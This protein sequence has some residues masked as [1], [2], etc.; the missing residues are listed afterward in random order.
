MATSTTAGL[1]SPELY[2]KLNTLS[3]NYVEIVPRTEIDIN[4][5]TTI[6]ANTSITATLMTIS[7]PTTMLAYKLVK[8]PISFTYN[9]TSTIFVSCYVTSGI[10]LSSGMELWT[11]KTMGASYTVSNALYFKHDEKNQIYLS[12]DSET[13]PWTLVTY[14]SP[15]TFYFSVDVKNAYSSSCSLYY[16]LHNGFYEIRGL[17]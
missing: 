16:R 9:F 1:L 15:T 5:S 6:N 7:L 3:Y 2:E 11:G 8:I 4:S 12:I 13:G 17:E 10:K 14:V